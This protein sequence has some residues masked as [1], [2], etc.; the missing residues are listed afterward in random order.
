MNVVWIPG[1]LQLDKENSDETLP[2]DHMDAGISRDFLKT[3][4]ADA[5]KCLKVEDC[6]YGKCHLCG[7][8]DHK[9]LKPVVF[10]ECPEWQKEETGEGGRKKITDF[11]WI[12]ITYEKKGT[13]TVFR[14]PRTG[15]PVQSVVE[16]NPAPE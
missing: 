15:Q 6:R 12:E 11:N 9:I 16:K 10:N 2:W 4:W 14:T 3:Q 13:G 1:F 5:Q 7:V 8:C